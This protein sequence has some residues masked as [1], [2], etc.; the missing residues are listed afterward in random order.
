MMTEA[1][2]AGRIAATKR[3]IA[4]F[5]DAIAITEHTTRERPANVYPMLWVAMLRAYRVQLAELQEELRTLEAE[6]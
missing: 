6:Q 4:I 2:R 1:E 5:E 3:G